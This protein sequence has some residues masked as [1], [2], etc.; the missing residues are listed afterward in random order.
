MDGWTLLDHLKRDPDTRHIPVQVISVMDREHGLTWGPSPIWKSPVSSEALEGAFAHMKNFLDRDVKELLVV[1]D[2]AVQRASIVEL[3]GNGDV[4]V[5]AVGTAKR[6]WP[7]F[8]QTIR[9]HGA[10]SGIAGPGGL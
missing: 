6:L 2:D 9:L 7:R 5:T 1:E 8:E 4:A 3:I 10:G